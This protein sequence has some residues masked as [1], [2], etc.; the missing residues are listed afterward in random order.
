MKPTNHKPAPPRCTA[1]DSP[2]TPVGDRRSSI[3]DR[4]SAV[5]RRPR[6]R[7]FVGSRTRMVLSVVVCACVHHVCEN[8]VSPTST[9]H[10]SRGLP[11]EPCGERQLL[12]IDD[13]QQPRPR[14]M[15][16]QHSAADGRTC[17]SEQESHL[18]RRSPEWQVRTANRGGV[19]RCNVVS[20]KQVFVAD[21]G[22]GGVV[23]GAKSELA[24][25]SANRTAVRRGAPPLVANH[26]NPCQA[27]L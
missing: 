19:A 25:Q 2:R 18:R 6:S 9:V 27:T 4:R 1:P 10:H 13:K 17:G 20:I 7:S 16:V 24:S 26:N 8:D 22:R 12:H 21:A 3:A 11:R 23:G 14:P 5:G 15:G